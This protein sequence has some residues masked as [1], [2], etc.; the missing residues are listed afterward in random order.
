VSVPGGGRLFKEAARLDRSNFSLANGVRAAVVVVSPLVLGAATGNLSLVFSTLGAMLLTNTEGPNSAGLPLRFLALAALTEP[1]A[2]AMGTAVALTGPGAIPLV[3]VGVCIGMLAGDGIAVAQVGRFTAVFFAVGVGLPGASAGAI[4]T[5]FEFA[6]GGALLALAGYWAQRELG[7][8]KNDRLSEDFWSVGRTKTGLG[9]LWPTT[10]SLKEHVF[11]W[12]IA[13][14][15]A[16]SVGL[17][18]GLAL[19]LARDFWI[20]VTLIIATRPRLGP[21]ISL[22]LTIVLG[23]FVGAALAAAITLSIGNLYFL[24]VLLFLFGILMFSARG[25]N[26]G[27]VQIFFTPFVIILLNILYSGE[28]YLAGV[29]VLDVAIGG[30]LAVMTVYALSAIESGRPRRPHIRA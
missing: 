30:A 2:F 4:I 15:V 23:T 6:F 13:V 29:R 9:Q 28:W 1:A 19:G 11:R 8:T 14:G 24:E 12:S 17:G 7:K 20:V 10:L 5:R 22:T 26:F 21:T 27:L 25:V 3:G 18:I 16:S